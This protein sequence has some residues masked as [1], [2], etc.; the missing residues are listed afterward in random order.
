MPSGNPISARNSLLSTAGSAAALAMLLKSFTRDLFP[1]QYSDLKH[2]MLS[3]LQ[4]FYTHLCAEITMVIEEAIDL[5][6]NQ[7]YSAAETYLRSKSFPSTR[8]FKL[9]KTEKKADYV[10]TPKTLD[11]MTDVFEGVRFKWKR[12]SNDGNHD[13]HFS[14]RSGTTKFFELS[15][16]KKHKDKV[17]NSY[18]P[19]IINQANDLKKE[20]RVVKLYKLGDGNFD[21]SWSS[22]HLHHPVTFDKLAMDD[23]QKK[24]IMDDLDRFVKRKDFYRRV[25]KAWKRGYLLYGPPGT[26]KSSLVAAMANYLNFDIY[27]LE[28]TSLRGNSDFRR[29]LVSTKNQ[30]IL[31]MEDMDCS[32][33][34]QN[35]MQMTYKIAQMTLS[36]MLNFMDGLWSSCGDER[37]IIVTTNNKDRLNPALLRPGRMDV[38]IHMTYCTP[39]GFRLLANNYLMVTDHPAFEEIEKLMEITNVTPAEVAETFMVSENPDVA[40]DG[41][42]RL[43]NEKHLTAI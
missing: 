17:L 38:H 42:A 10:I 29:L 24:M 2:F 1:F 26:G 33:D 12:V 41:L 11:E 4:K 25:G 20:S 8:K 37:I 31:V 5:T 27:D 9:S 28:L 22:I 19:F 3:A 14:R 16:H 6:E 21:S 32:V 35:P 15:F 23:A 34:F 30:S 13:L 39:C 40:L 7:V 43:L 36:G 18:L